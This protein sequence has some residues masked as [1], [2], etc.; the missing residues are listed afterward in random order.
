MTAET[1]ASVSDD[2]INHSYP[3]SV[4]IK[5]DRELTPQQ[6]TLSD[7]CCT[8]R[9]DQHMCAMMYENFQNK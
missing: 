5:K 1:P 4:H 2:I 8:P 7:Q 9:K 3:Q 6:N